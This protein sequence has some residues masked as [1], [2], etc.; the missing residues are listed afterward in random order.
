MNSNPPICDD[1]TKEYTSVTSEGDEIVDTS[2]LRS[3]VWPHFQK[4]KLKLTDVC[5]IKV[6]LSEW[7]ICGIDHVEEMA[8]NMIEKYD[9]EVLGIEMAE[10]IRARCYD[11]LTLYQGKANKNRGEPTTSTS[12]L[13]TNSSKP[14]TT[15]FK[16]ISRLAQY[17][18]Y[19][20]NL[21]KAKT[22]HVKSELEYYLEEEELP[23]LE[24]EDFDIL[25][26]WKSNGLKYPTL[27]A[28]ARDVLAV[29]VSTV[30]SESAFSTSGRVASSSRN[31]LHPKTL[32]A[33]MC[34]QSWLKAFEDGGARI[35]NPRSPFGSG[36]EEKNKS[37]L[38]I[39][40]GMG[41]GMW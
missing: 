41:M 16:C 10:D 2:S 39:G 33:L 13:S 9:K 23:R 40:S 28:I 35:P 24:G 21:K 19:R 14:P 3:D 15:S 38:G 4:I 17:D 25:A 34:T 37:P 31:R 6:T 32:E 36:M 22:I 5:D 30:A 11:L 7:A 20:D 8:N 29:P 27:Q 12:S 1:V 18:S 26:W